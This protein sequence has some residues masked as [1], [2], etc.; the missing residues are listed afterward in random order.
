DGSDEIV[1]NSTLHQT[2]GISCGKLAGGAPKQCYLPNRYVCN[3][4]LD[5]FFGEDESNCS[6]TFDC[7][8]TSFGRNQYKIRI[9]FC[10]KVKNCL[11]NADEIPYS[12]GIPGFQCSVTKTHLTNYCM[13]PEQYVCDGTNDCDY[14]T[15]ECFCT[16]SNDYVGASCFRCLNRQL[17]IPNTLRCDGSFHCNDLSDECL[18]S[19]PP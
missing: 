8:L 1:F 12:I 15:D 16:N 10:D 6:H 11:N 2:T 4:E 9:Q 3:H 14:G 5:C 18:C 7:G 17:V 19:N 13:L